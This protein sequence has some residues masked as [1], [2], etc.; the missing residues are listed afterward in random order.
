MTDKPIPK[1]VDVLFS[2]RE[3]P[4]NDPAELVYRMTYGL[5]LPHAQAIKHFRQGMKMIS[6]GLLHDTV[7]NWLIEHGFPLTTPYKLIWE[8]GYAWQKVID[9]IESNPLAWDSEREARNKYLNETSKRIEEEQ[10]KDAAIEWFK[11][12][13]L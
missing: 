9:E 8:P 13:K 1:D 5:P 11:A 6:V 4:D 10:G 7:E 12:N 3:R 2:Y